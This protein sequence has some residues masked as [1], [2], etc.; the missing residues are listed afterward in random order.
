M[1]MMCSISF[2]RSSLDLDLAILHEIYQ[3]VTF[4]E[5]RGSI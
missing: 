3:G 1:Y 4:L 5:I 2:M